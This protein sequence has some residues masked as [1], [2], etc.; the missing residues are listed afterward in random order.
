MIHFPWPKAGKFS[1]HRMAGDAG[2]RLSGSLDSRR[3][4]GGCIAGHGMR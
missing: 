3:I 4:K 2:R 1:P